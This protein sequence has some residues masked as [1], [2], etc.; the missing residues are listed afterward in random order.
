MRINKFFLLLMIAFSLL[1]G[2]LF[3]LMIWEG[4]R[5]R[6]LSEEQRVRERKISAPRGLIKD[7]N[8]QVL[9]RNKPVYKK[10]INGTTDQPDNEEDFKII[11]HE[12]A[13][14]IEA[15]GGAEAAGLRIDVARDYVWG[16]VL[17]HVIG[18][19]GEA[20]EEE[21][22][23][24]TLRQSSGQRS[25]IQNY[26]LGDR[27]G[28]MGVE[29]EY[30]ESLRGVDGKELIETDAQG[31]PIR[32]LGKIDPKAGEDLTLSID[33][34]LQKKAAEG[35]VDQAGVV[36]VSDPKTGEIL[37]LYSSPSFDPNF[38]VGGTYEIREILEDQEEPLFNRAIAGLYPPGSV[39]KI[40]TAAAG[41]EEGVI[42]RTTEIE[43]VGAIQIGPYRF[44][45]WFFDQY[46]KKEGMV[47]IVKAIK[48]SNDIFFYKVG[49]I[50][51]VEKLAQWGRRFGVGKGLGIDIPGEGEGVM[52]D[53]QWREVVKNDQWFLGD[54]YHLSIGQGDLLV[55]P[56]QVNFWTGVVTNGGKLC[57]P[58]LK[59][60]EAT[61]DELHNQCQAIGL[62]EET[63]SL[64]KEGMKGACEP[65]GTGWPLFNFKIKSENLKI[66]GKNFL[67]AGSGL[68][69][70]PT[71]CKTGTAE[72]G[73]PQ[74]KT[75]AWFTVF[76]PFK[77]PE[78]VVTVLVEGGGEGSY[79]AAPIAKEILEEW[80][81]R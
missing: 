23:S 12:E 19:T 41:L 50:V 27:I 5:Y 71:G 15:K 22:Q 61:R 44:G 70:I 77:D 24:S 37:A 30:D 26:E 25:E 35:L 32:V 36:V 42:D 16:G 14:E 69:E 13:V 17:A 10:L 56:L 43:D 33:L 34:S 68:V 67:D 58:V 39:F 20:T 28:R 63:I 75:H 74:D 2:R 54:T 65:G 18:Y 80:F 52:P 48:R 66:D 72:F 8:G 38:F 1:L 31:V 29:E 73:D 3:Q 4:K 53:P 9:V 57:Q 51:G 49:E 40:I 60:L 59:K 76:A 6:T 7:R 79:V 47:D 78:I 11:S 55:T 62:K 64:I 46:G 21:I 45:N 81:G